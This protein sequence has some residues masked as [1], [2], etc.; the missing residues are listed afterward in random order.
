MSQNLNRDREWTG[1]SLARVARGVTRASDPE[2]LKEEV[3][4]AAPVPLP[5]EPSH[6]VTVEVGVH[7]HHQSL[8]SS[9]EE[10]NIS[11]EK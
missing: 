3:P 6:K 5:C 1:E 7:H 2:P 11:P 9:H 10:L 8:S 4:K